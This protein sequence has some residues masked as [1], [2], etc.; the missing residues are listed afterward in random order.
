METATKIP[1]AHVESAVSENPVEIPMMESAGVAS[2][3]T[4]QEI[5]DDFE[6]SEFALRGDAPNRLTPI[7]EILALP[8]A[9]GEEP[10]AKNPEEPSK[11]VRDAAYWQ[12]EHDKKEY[13]HKLDLQN[14]RD[15]ILREVK[16]TQPQAKPEPVVELVA[17]KKPRDF[18]AFEAENNPDSESYKYREAREQYLVDKATKAVKDEFQQREAKT[19]QTIRRQQAVSQIEQTSFQL[20]GNDQAKAKAFVDYLNSPESYSLEFMYKAFEAKNGNRIQPP[21]NAEESFKQNERNNL[22]PTDPGLVT[23]EA[24]K[25]LN[26]EQRF[27]Q[28]RARGIQRPTY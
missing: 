24:P 26:D 8:K 16:A 21:S 13:Q 1:D 23:G 28:A 27:N 20:A 11:E 19:N 3:N 6:N 17:P 25:T 14:L 18:D 7:D 2:L 9:A 5:P 12:S 4:M 15:E 22:M 10:S